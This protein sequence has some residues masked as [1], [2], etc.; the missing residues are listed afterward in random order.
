[1]GYSE[2]RTS[3]ALLIDRSLQAKQVHKDFNSEYV[4]APNQSDVEDYDTAFDKIPPTTGTSKPKEKKV[5]GVYNPTGKE[6]S[7]LVKVFHSLPRVHQHK[8]LLTTRNV[9]KTKED[10]KKWKKEPRY[11]DIQGIDTQPEELME[12]RVGVVQSKVG[13]IPVRV[14]PRLSGSYGRYR[15]TMTKSDLGFIEMNKDIVGNKKQWYSTLFHELGHAYDR[16]LFTKEYDYAQTGNVNFKT[17]DINF[18]KMKFLNSPLSFGSMN[19]KSLKIRDILGKQRDKA[20]F[21][22]RKHSPYTDEQGK[23]MITVGYGRMTFHK[24]RMQNNEL[25]ANWFSSFMT[26]KSMPKKESRGFYNVF[27]KSNK[28]LF[29]ALRKS[30]AGVTSK[31]MGGKL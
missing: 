14:N 31:F 12:K 23:R 3:H 24:Y 11:Y 9:I 4:S 22:T 8:D 1:M 16:N 27:K 21:V 19:N 20:V 26:N 25:F 7:E 5:E 13:N 15:H 30:D 10:V 17:G 28:D 2:K 6:R 18:K 29:R